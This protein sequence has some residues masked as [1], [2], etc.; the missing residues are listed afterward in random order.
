MWIASQTRH[1]MKLVNKR[2][3]AVGDMVIGDTAVSAIADVLGADEIVFAQ[4]NMGAIG[5]R[6]PACAPESWQGEAG[7]GVDQVARC[8]FEFGRVD[9]LSVD[10]A[11][12]LGGSDAGGVA[13]GL[14][15][16]EIAAVAEHGEDIA[17]FRPCKLGISA[18]GRPEVARV[19]ACSG[20]S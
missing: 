13:G 19:A 8:C 1:G 4:Q 6:C 3:V 16:T 18:G 15:G 20:S 17:L 5:D 7:I 11:Q 9:V 14:T 10:P 2:N 12:R